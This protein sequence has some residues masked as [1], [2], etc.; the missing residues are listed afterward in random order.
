MRRITI[1][2]SNPSRPRHK[3]HTHLSRRSLASHAA[4]FAALKVPV[5]VI[6]SPSRGCNGWLGSDCRRRLSHFPIDATAVRPQR[7]VLA[8]ALGA[9]CRGRSWELRAGITADRPQPPVTRPPVHPRLAVTIIL[10]LRNRNQDHC[11][12]VRSLP[13]GHADRV[14]WIHAGNSCR[15]V[16]TDN[17]DRSGV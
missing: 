10:L 15:I 3:C 4:Q 14:K 9:I 1:G 6:W 8:T 11:P 17:T 16:V 2:V 7:S 12:D 5:P 13:G